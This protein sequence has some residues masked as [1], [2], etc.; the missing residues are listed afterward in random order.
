MP[1]SSHPQDQPALRRD[2]RAELLRAR[3]WTDRLFALLSP[4][5]L[6]ERPIAER[7]RLLFY[8]GHLEAFDFNLVCRDVLGQR[9]SRPS[10][11]PL[12]AFGIDPVGGELP[13]DT[14]ADWPR[15]REVEEWNGELRA[16]VDTAARPG[17][18]R[19]CSPRCRCR[20]TGPRTSATRRPRPMRAGAAD[21]CPPKRSGTAR[22]LRCG[23]CHSA[24]TSGAT[25]TGCASS[26][27]PLNQQADG[28]KLLPAEVARRFRSSRALAR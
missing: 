10:F 28:D 7:H 18:S 16:A 2:L 14:P 13:I 25:A 20:S 3:A 12:F 27:S 1:T 11:E 17:R 19:R 22:P 8:L 6:Y 21:A 23:H 24:P 5:A 26:R 15:Q 9:S 4:E